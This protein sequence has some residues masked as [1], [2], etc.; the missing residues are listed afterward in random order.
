VLGWG[1]DV[2]VLEPDSF[3][4]RVREEIHKMLKRY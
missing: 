3:R 4:I 2:T 1:A